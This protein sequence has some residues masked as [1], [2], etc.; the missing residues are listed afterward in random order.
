LSA[1]NLACFGFWE[2]LAKPDNL[3]R[4]LFRPKLQI[5]MFHRSLADSALITQNSPL[6]KAAHQLVQQSF[7]NLACLGQH[8]GGLPILTYWGRG[9]QAMHLPCKQAY[10]GAL[11]IGSISLRGTRLKHREKPHKLL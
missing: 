9:R 2:T 3:Q 8:Q 11:P 1:Q 4:K 7:Q 6:E 5:P 10:M